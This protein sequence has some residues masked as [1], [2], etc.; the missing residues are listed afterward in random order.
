MRSAWTAISVWS[1]TSA[2]SSRTVG[3][4]CSSKATCAIGRRGARTIADSSECASSTVGASGG[5]IRTSRPRSSAARA[6]AGRC[7]TVP[8]TIATWRLVEGAAPAPRATGRPSSIASGLG[9]LR[10]RVVDPCEHAA[11]SERA[12]RARM[13][14][15]GS[16]GAEDDGPHHVPGD[17]NPRRSRRL[18]AGRY[19]YNAAECAGASAR[20]RFPL[21]RHSLPSW[22]S[23]R[24]WSRSPTSSPSGC[25]STAGSRTTTPTCCRATLP[26]RRRGVAC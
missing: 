16:A 24:R 23:T 15:T 21:H 6:S 22:A 8:P 17:R 14:L 18:S 7:S 19:A 5:S 11:V 3:S 20:L 26:L 12:K 1:A 25:A 13:S 4:K 9:R 10:V 2:R